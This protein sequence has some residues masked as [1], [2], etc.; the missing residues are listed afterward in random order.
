MSAGCSGKLGPVNNIENAPIYQNDGPVELRRVRDAI[1]A[2]LD[3]KGWGIVDES[4]GWILARVDVSDHWAKIRI[5]YDTQSYTILHFESS[6]GLG[7]NGAQIHRRY[8]NWIEYLDE[9]IQEALQNPNS[10]D[11]DD[12]DDEAEEA[13]DAIDEAAAEAED[14]AEAVEEAAEAEEAADTPAPGEG[15]S[16]EPDPSWNEGSAEAPPPT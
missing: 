5:T 6:P 13:A 1:A 9:E 14:A 4:Q 15:P 10:D 8:N 7:Y 11:D 16:P 2:G 3:E 12:D